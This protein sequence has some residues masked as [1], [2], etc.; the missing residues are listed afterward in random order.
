MAAR[1]WLAAGGLL[2]AALLLFWVFRSEPPPPPIARA[3]APQ[4]ATAPPPPPPPAAAMPDVSGL[5]LHGLLATGA[6]VAG[7]GGSQRLIPI[8]REALPGLVLRRI[9]QNHAVFASAA[10]EV[11]LGFDG[12]AQAAAGAA[13]ASA[14][15]G[16]DVLPYRLG[17]APRR[18]GG[19]VT[20]FTV[21]PGASLP[22]LERAGIRP[23]DVILA[24]NGSRFDEE[25][26]LEL[27][28]QIANSTRTEFAVERAG[29]RMQMRL[30]AR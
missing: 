11:R 29:R 30:P 27:P 1:G 10:G 20:G 14:P 12:P 19:Q 13:P 3:A 7:G 16:D 25:R 6:I 17:L 21:R 8:G 5:K 9:E 22:A 18:V 2:L 26:M 4:A 23:G 28:W 15:P 24:V